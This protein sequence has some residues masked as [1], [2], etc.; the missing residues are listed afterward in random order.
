KSRSKT[1]YPSRTTVKTFCM[2]SR[3]ETNSSI[4]YIFPP[5][6]PKN[7]QDTSSS[8]DPSILP[9]IIAPQLP[10]NSHPISL[11]SSNIQLPYITP[12]P[13]PQN[14]Q[15]VTP[16]KMSTLSS[17]E[18]GSVS[19]SDS[20]ADL[21]AEAKKIE[22]LDMP[23]TLVN[24]LIGNVLGDGKIENDAR[25]AVIRSTTA[26][27]S[28]LARSASVISK[29]QNHKTLQ[30]DDVFRAIE[31]CNLGEFLPRLK[32]ELNAFEVKK[33]AAKA[34]HNDD[35]NEYTGGPPSSSVVIN[36]PSESDVMVK[37]TN[38]NG[39]SS[40]N[41][42]GTKR[43]FEEEI[44]F[45]GDPSRTPGVVVSSSDRQHMSTMLPSV[46]IEHNHMETRANKIDFIDD[47]SDLSSNV[48]TNESDDY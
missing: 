44:S 11:S 35:D 14:Y 30:T 20:E 13:P 38:P 33:A 8:P 22:D 15:F 5:S 46:S 7:Y 37:I 24:K 9:Y 41:T 18:V 10:E 17:E 3:S 31:A 47:V 1:L 2:S 26:F 28:H 27:I 42:S 43:K 19:S 34:K 23:Q 16:R 4:P 32:S 6:P 39:N 45:K 21:N 29:E 36:L 48:G 12:P 25:L 40:L